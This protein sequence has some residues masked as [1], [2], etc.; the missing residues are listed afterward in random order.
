M[1]NNKL[2][3]AK[4]LLT[5]LIYAVATC[6]IQ[7]PVANLLFSVLH[8]QPNSGISE[9]MVPFLLLSIFAVGTAMAYFYYLYGHLFNSGRKISTAL[10]FSL[11]VYF[12]NYI[13]QV[14]FLDA[15]KGL[16]K[17]IT[18][19]FAVIQVE[20]FDL[21]ILLITVLLMVCYMPHRY[22]KTQ[23]ENCG[24]KNCIWSNILCGV[25]FAAV[26][27]TVQEIILPLFGIKNMADGLNVAKENSFFFYT[28][29]T[30]G[31]LLAGYLVALYAGK[32]TERKFFCIEYGIFIWCAFDLTM[33]PLG[34]GLLATI[35]FMLVSMAGFAGAEVFKKRMQ[36]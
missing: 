27:I 16:Q 22:E 19:G 24:T 13:P 4:C 6:V 10:K 31:F 28:V 25:I 20:L 14:F 34:F 9:E 23:G 3:I 11:F 17:L 21:L 30:L 33:I 26:L 1:K 32:Q 36:K 29:M 35:I 7:V 12:S 8:I 18:G 5:G 15:D 2:P